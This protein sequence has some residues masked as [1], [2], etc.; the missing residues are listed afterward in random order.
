MYA[1]AWRRHCGEHVDFARSGSG[2]NFGGL[3]GNVAG[4][5]LFVFFPL[6]ADG[7][8]RNPPCVEFVFVDFDEVRVIRQ[9]LAEAAKA[10]APWAGLFKHIFEIHAE[11]AHVPAA[12]PAVS[13]ASALVA[14]SADKF[15]LL[16][17]SF[18]LR[19][20]GT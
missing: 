9:A 12:A 7:E 19:K 4:H 20:R 3:H 8:R 18:T 1:Q 6:A 13:T 15:L 17:F 16:S 10:H 14:V 11:A 2:K 5:F